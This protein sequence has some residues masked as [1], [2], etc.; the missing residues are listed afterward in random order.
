M[1]G[2]LQALP[3]RPMDAPAEPHGL[4]GAGPGIGR[5]LVRSRLIQYLPVQALQRASP[6]QG[7]SSRTTRIEQAGAYHACRLTKSGWQR[8]LN[9]AEKAMMSCSILACAATTR[10]GQ[11]APL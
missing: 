11:A 7:S 9:Q 5:T 6:N 10:S 1:L 3:S 8:K 4:P 2:A